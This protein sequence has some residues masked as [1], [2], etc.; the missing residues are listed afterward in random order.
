M[1][2]GEEKEK[3]KKKKD[4]GGGEKAEAKMVGGTRDGRPKKAQP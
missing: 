2:E 4:G 3:K 1:R